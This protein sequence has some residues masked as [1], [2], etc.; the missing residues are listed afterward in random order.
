MGSANEWPSRQA[1]CEGVCSAVTHDRHIDL[2]ERA[3]TEG[4]GGTYEGSEGQMAERHGAAVSSS[5]DRI[6]I[7]TLVSYHGQ[8]DGH[9][10]EDVLRGVMDIF[11]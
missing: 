1:G 9:S 7:L 4:A 11:R 2:D 6:S 5:P 8:R 3:C 10:T